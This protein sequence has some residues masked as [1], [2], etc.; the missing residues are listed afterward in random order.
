MLRKHDDDAHHGQ[1]IN[2]V[3]AS[4]EAYPMV[5]TLVAVPGRSK[6]QFMLLPPPLDRSDLL[7]IVDLG[8]AAEVAQPCKLPHMSC[9]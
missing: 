4:A 2:T 9:T 1:V 8:K 6:Q 3:Y 7:A 5:P